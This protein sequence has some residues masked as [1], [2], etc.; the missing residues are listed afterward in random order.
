MRNIEKGRIYIQQQIEHDMKKLPLIL[1]LVLAQIGAAQTNV[2]IHGMAVGADGKDIELYRYSDPLSH[3][4]LLVDKDVI[5]DDQ[6]F[7]LKAY[8]NYP[9]LMFIQVEN[10]SQSFYVEAGKDYEIYIP[11]FDWDLDEKRNIYLAPEALPIEFMNVK[12]DDINLQISAFE[13]L[14]DSFVTANRYHLE[15]KFRPE[16]RY[17]DTLVMLVEKT[18]PKGGDFVERYKKYKLAELGYNMHFESRA[19]MID[20]YIKDQPI[21]YYDESYMNLFQALYGN[22]IS[23]GSR[24]IDIY[25]LSH[26]VDQGR[27]D[28]MRDSLGVDPMLRNEQVRELAAL[29]ALKEAYNNS[30]YY[31]RE[32]VLNMIK[33]LGATTKFDQVARLAEHVSAGMQDM[34]KGAEVPVFELPDVDK[35]VV[36]LDSFAGKWVYLS[37]IRVGDPNSIGEIETLAHFKDSVYAKSKNVEFVTIVCDR[38]FQKMYHFL[39]NSRHSGKYSWTWL[40]FNSNFKLLEKYHVVSYPTFLLINPDG[41]LQYSVTPT[42]ASG[43]LLSPPWQEKKEAELSP[44]FL[45]N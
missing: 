10:Y 41:Q 25:R 14:L 11:R 43:F 12:N 17:F 26:W 45:G 24:Y 9:T 15:A 3:Q 39:K 28:V 32:A 21:L 8:A 36:S 5:G 22:T 19:R 16:K 29:I 40:H 4:E 27:I 13:N 31:N 38:E 33:K 2:R 7:E 42:P 18:L 37:F 30:R 23:K 6:E 34:E 44:F 35:Q 20:T 1:M